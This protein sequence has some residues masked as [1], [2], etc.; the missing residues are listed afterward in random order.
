M[1]PKATQYLILTVLFSLLAVGGKT[2]LCDVLSVV[3]VESHHHPH[4][5]AQG[6]AGAVC[7]GNHEHGQKE[8]PCPESCAIRLAEAPAPLLQK[9]PAVSETFVLP[10]LLEVLLATEV[11]GD[12]HRVFGKRAGP[13]HLPSLL[14]PTFTGRYLV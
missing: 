12:F 14:D 9:V 3:G 8:V 1:V 6:G 11:P 10:F 13:D 5:E 7:L 4:D 2:T